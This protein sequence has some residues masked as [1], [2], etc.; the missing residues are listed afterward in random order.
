M[1]EKEAVLWGIHA[2]KTGAAD[3]L[4]LTKNCI[5]IGWRKMGDLSKLRADREAFKA[6][7]AESYPDLV[8]GAI[9][10]SAGQTFR[11]VHE[12]KPGDFVVYPPKQTRVVHIGKIEG[13]Y[14]YDPDLAGTIR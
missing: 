12:M 10:N 3:S 1:S 2:G 9:R 4:F 6:K 14:K 5:A 13:Q 7:V 11:F 8:A